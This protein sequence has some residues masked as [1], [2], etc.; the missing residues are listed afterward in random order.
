MD[1]IL[2]RYFH[3]IMLFTLVSTV[4]VQHLLIEDQLPRKE[5]KRIS[6]VDRMYGISAILA[7]AS[8]LT[9][10]FVVGKPQEFYSANWIFHTKVSLVVIVGLLSIVP[11][12]FF[13]KNC[14]GEEDEIVSVP[15]K[16][17]HLIRAQL[18]LIFLIP[19]LAV[20]MAQGRGSF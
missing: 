17:K 19:L 3:F 5:I 8:G 12:R 4:V 11:T 13:I 2:L 16:I 10:W 1:Y 6:L 18:L 9:L 20:L 7:V 14:K 15:S